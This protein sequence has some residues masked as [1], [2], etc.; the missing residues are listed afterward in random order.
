MQHITFAD[1]HT[2]SNAP[3]LFRPPKLSSAEPG[4]YSGGGP[5]GKPSGCCQLLYFFACRQFVLPATLFALMGKI[6]M[7]GVETGSQAWSLYDTATL[8]APVPTRTHAQTKH[9]AVGG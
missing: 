5:P 2:A 7:P 1:G 9:E 8:H 3:D 6:R 4:Q